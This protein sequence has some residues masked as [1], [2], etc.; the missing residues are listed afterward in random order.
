MCCRSTGF[1]AA[2]VSWGFAESGVCSVNWSPGMYWT[3]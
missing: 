3:W 2:D 1:D